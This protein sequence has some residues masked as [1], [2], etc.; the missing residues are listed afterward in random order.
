MP[1][2]GAADLLDAKPERFKKFGTH[3]RSRA[4]SVLA[5]ASLQ[6]FFREK[7]RVD[8]ADDAAFLVHDGES[9]KFVKHEKF[10]RIENGSLGGNSDDPTYH[11]FA[12]RRFERRGQQAPRGHYACQSLLF[13]N[14]VK[15]NDPLTHPLASDALQRVAHSH[16][17]IEQR[18]ILS[19][20]LDDCSI[21]IGNTGSDV[22]LA[23]R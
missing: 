18:K 2:R 9:E 23:T 14:D 21:E 15:I 16:V 5:L 19:R 1:R 11:D 22:H 8:D 13:I 6:N 10:A 20:M 4:V 3:R 17:R 12:Q 7:V